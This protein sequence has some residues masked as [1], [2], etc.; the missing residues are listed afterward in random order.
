MGA[1]QGAGQVHCESI[2]GYWLSDRAPRAY[3]PQRP[4]NPQPITRVGA[5]RR[6]CNRFFRALSD[7]GP[8]GVGESST[9]DDDGYFKQPLQFSRRGS[10]LHV[11]LPRRAA[12]ENERS[13]ALVLVTGTGATLH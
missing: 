2:I 5:T 12:A 3:P 4:G 13:P 10:G 6:S 11:R 9:A 8:C 7:P 1:A